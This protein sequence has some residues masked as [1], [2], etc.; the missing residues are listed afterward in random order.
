MEIPLPE[1]SHELCISIDG[2][3]YNLNVTA[4]AMPLMSY[5]TLVLTFDMDERFYDDFEIEDVYLHQ[6]Y[7]V[8]NVESALSNLK[9]LRTNIE[10]IIDQ[11]YRAFEE[12]DWEFKKLPPE[13][14]D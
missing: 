11:S 7:P 1:V 6:F 4:H 12:V 3:E 14:D 10:W 5:Y 2:Q 13:E 9:A 8:E